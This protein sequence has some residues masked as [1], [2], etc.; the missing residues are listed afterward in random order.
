MAETTPEDR[1]GTR[2]ETAKTPTM[3][4]PPPDRL[5]T[6]EGKVKVAGRELEYTAVAGTVTLR[7]DDG[8]PKCQVFFVSYMRGDVKDRERRPLVFAFN[9]GPGSSSTWL[10]MGILGP[11]RVVVGEAPSAPPAPYLV[12]DN[13]HSLLDVADIVFIDPVATGYS[14]PVEGEEP[15]QFFGMREDAQWV[16]EFIRAYLSINKR[17]TSPKYLVGESYGTARAALLS[18]V[19][20]DDHGI[21][22]NGIALVSAVLTYASLVES[23]AND[24][25]YVTAL[26]SM[27]AVAH[28][29]GR[30]GSRYRDLEK[31]CAEVEE[32]ALGGYLSHLARGNAAGE[33]ERRDVARKLAGYT[34]LSEAFWRN[35][36][37]RV[38]A[39]R[40]RRELLRSERQVVGRF[41]GRYKGFDRDAAGENP[42]IDPSYDVVAGAYA[43]AINQ[44]LAAELNF[45]SEARYRVLTRVEPW[46]VFEPDGVRYVDI[47]GSL[48]QAMAR[49][50][51]MKVL[52]ASGYYDLATSYFASEWATRQ[53]VFEPELAANFRLERYEAGHM[54]YTH[55]PSA[56]K[57][58]KDLLEL[59]GGH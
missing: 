23:T 28:F 19:L 31:L 9:G 16:A 52:V 27:A 5:S 13:P 29:H 56:K 20:Q 47:A 37:N 4:E 42:S 24:L 15:K 3:K 48:G 46:S 33:K 44:Y 54:M 7:D 2:D 55:E 10:H 18:L 38:G 49:N 39:S 45:S 58:R 41:D 12:E 32:F 8:K 6:T 50:P 53:L 34:G 11:R 21:H 14:R 35:S 59:I 30:L 26:P 36:N 57:L 1:T 25:P 22:V 40:F 43:A 17:W 51:A